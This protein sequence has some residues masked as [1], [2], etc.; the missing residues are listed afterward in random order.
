M[1]SAQLRFAS[2]N[3]Q[4]K[5]C[6]RCVTSL[7]AQ[8]AVL[9]PVERVQLGLWLYQVR[10]AEGHRGRETRAFAGGRLKW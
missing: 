1:Q 6:P 2:V 5:Y 8:S 9:E 10:G 7:Q 3:L 4:G